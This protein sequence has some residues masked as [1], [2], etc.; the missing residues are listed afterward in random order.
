MIRSAQFFQPV[1]PGVSATVDYTVPSG[2]RA[3]CK[4]MTVSNP[5][6]TAYQITV[7]LVPSGGSPGATNV[8][9][10]GITVPPNSVLSLAQYFCNQVMNVGDTIQSL[11]STAAKLTLMAG[12]F[13]ETT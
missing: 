13:E 2:F 1:Q 11:A 5:N 8:L 4:Q 3:D 9:V 6:A 7:Y 12:G 10:P